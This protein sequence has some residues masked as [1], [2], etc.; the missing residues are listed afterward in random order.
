MKIKTSPSMILKPHYE[1]VIKVLLE[2]GVNH[3]YEVM[4]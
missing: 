2:I 4:I 1:S 3:E